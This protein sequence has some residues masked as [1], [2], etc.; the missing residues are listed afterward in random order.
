MPREAFCR[1]LKR[2]QDEVLNLGGMVDR[3]IARSVEALKN[4]DLEESRRIIEGDLEINRKR[5]DLEEKCL[6]LLATQ[7]PLAG[8]LRLI[9]AVL[10]IITELERMGDHAE[11]IARITIMM[12]EEPLVKPLIDIP[13][14][15]HIVERMLHDSLQAFVRRDLDL[16]SEAVLMDDEVDHLYK[17]LHRELAEFVRRDPELVEQAMSLLLVGA[18]LERVADHI[19]NIGERIWFIETGKLKELHE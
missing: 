13:R 2:L 11:G 9:A 7:Q 12:S 18:Y 15:A 4:R 8:D 1:E 5:F 3:A 19:T 17:S 14:M 16:A 10:N 6:L